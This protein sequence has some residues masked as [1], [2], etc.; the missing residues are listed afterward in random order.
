M[1]Q[2]HIIK[3]LAKNDIKTKKATKLRN[4]ASNRTYYRVPKK[5]LLVAHMPRE[6]KESINK[7]K[8]TT[9]VLKQ[10]QIKVP[11][12]ID[13]DRENDL[14]LIEDFGETKLS[15]IINNQNKR[16]Y[17]KLCLDEIINLQKIKPTKAIKEFN[18]EKIIAETMLFVD[19]YLIK[20]QRKKITNTQKKIF[21]R[22]IK[23]LYSSVKGMYVCGHMDY[24]VDNIFY[25]K[26]SKSIGLIDYQDIKQTHVAY[27]V[28]SILQDVRNPIKK[29]LEK[30][31]VEYFLQKSNCNK[32]NFKSAYNFFSIQRNLKIIGIF[33]RL[34]HRDR[35]SNYYKLIPICFNL[36]KNNLKNA[37]AI[38]CK[39]FY[40]WLL[41]EY[42]I[43]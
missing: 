31:L 2:K 8:M 35:K 14:L 15:K 34:K 25:F 26:N 37:K 22:K 27:D 6:K 4:D 19:W 41:K 13:T 12:I 36:I 16:K 18:V 29:S 1:N 30:E 11:N 20:D 5:N 42:E 28:L 33:S 3:L 32:Y 17:L 21:K 10:N 38:K 24:H 9:R 23:D 40:Q 7:F 43:V 39:N